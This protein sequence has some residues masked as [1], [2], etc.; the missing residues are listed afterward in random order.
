M[1]RVILLAGVSA[2]VGGVSACG[3]LSNAYTH[4]V[5]WTCISNQ[6]CDRADV[7]REFDRAWVGSSELRL[8]S[9]GDDTSG[10]AVSRVP[11][12]SVPENCDVLL[13]LS[14][15]GHALEPVSFCR[16]PG[17]FEFELSIPDSNPTSSS[18]WRVEM[19][20]L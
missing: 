3:D 10:A 5:S 4:S 6:G 13:G 14:L 9:A 2:L 17:G 12:D 15:F 1:L 11:S 7:V 8:Y 20:S 19:Q 18:E 16:V